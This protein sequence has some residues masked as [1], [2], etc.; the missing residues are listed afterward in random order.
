ME[1]AM[2]Y[3]RDIYS[4]MVAS[5]L[6][7]EGYF[8]DEYRLYGFLYWIDNET[9]FITAQKEEQCARS[10]VDMVE[11]GALVTP[12]VSH[13]VRVYEREKVEETMVALKEKI[14]DSLNEK[15]AQ[16][17]AGKKSRYKH[18]SISSN[19]DNYL[20][21]YYLSLNESARREKMQALKWLA[22][23]SKKSR[24]LSQENY[25]SLLALI[26]EK[27]LA[28]VEYFKEIYG[29]AW[30]AADEW[31]YYENAFLPTVVQKIIHLH[32]DNCVTSGIV[33][34]KYSLDSKPVCELKAEFQVYL[35]KVLDDAY[36]DMVC[37]LAE[38]V[39]Q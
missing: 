19:T 3:H 26:P 11:K 7:K 33:S 29:F 30:Y 14:Y 22:G 28:S 4:G 38:T 16:D 13:G 6:T 25:D 32:N 18:I 37:K 31:K 10:Y 21:D 24:L 9:N 8:G 34:K 39:E 2:K 12:Y 27:D 20:R 15:Y 17:L 36:L 1:K 35:R 5:E 23:Y